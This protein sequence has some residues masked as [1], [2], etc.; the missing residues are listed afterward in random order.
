[1]RELLVQRPNASRFLWS[2]GYTPPGGCGRD[3][4]SGGVL[5]SLVFGLLVLLLT[6]LVMTSAAVAGVRSKA[7]RPVAAVAENAEADS[8]EGTLLAARRP[9]IPTRSWR[10]AQ[11]SQGASQPMPGEHAASSGEGERSD[12]GCAKERTKNA[13]RLADLNKLAKENGELRAKLEKCQISAPR[14]KPHEPERTENSEL[15]APTK[16]TEI[17]SKEENLEEKRCKAKLDKLEAKQEKKRM[18]HRADVAE[19]AEMVQGYRKAWE[20]CS[21][22]PSIGV[23]ELD[24]FKKQIVTAEKHLDTAF[25]ELEGIMSGAQ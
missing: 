6:L 19:L 13:H 7:V 11:A 16:G 17:A 9:S 15:T 3:K 5:V 8:A 23:E 10:F 20:K 2:S 21:K 25:A 4:A 1:M 14:P 18:K 22:E 24:E 12:R